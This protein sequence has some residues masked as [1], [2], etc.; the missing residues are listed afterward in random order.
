MMT[1]NSLKI[2]WRKFSRAAARRPF[3]I[4]GL[5]ALFFALALW[6]GMAAGGGAAAMNSAVNLAENSDDYT[7]TLAVANGSEPRMD[8]RMDGD[9]LRIAS[10]KSAG[11]ASY[12]QSF[13]LPQADIAQSP[14]FDRQPDKLVITVPKRSGAANAPGATMPQSM[15]GMDAWSQQL[16]GQFQRMQQQMDSMMNRAMSNVGQANPFAD[17]MGSGLMASGGGVQM[18]DKGKDYV[19]HASVP[20]GTLKDVKVTVD[21]DRVL[22][23]SAKDETTTGNSYQSSNY[24]QVLTLP[25]PVDAGQ[26][27]V[28]QGKGELVITLPKA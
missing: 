12:E 16:M 8:I 11:G 1:R 15:A 5:A 23:I 24:M 19:I 14:K 13:V 3:A 26:I 7:I 21:D 25:G 18:Q 6:A 28:D 10:G 20:G 27:K 17:V 22:K 4:G 2:G 9:T